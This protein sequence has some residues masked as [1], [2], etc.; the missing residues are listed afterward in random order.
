MTDAALSEGQLT[1]V[2]R[3]A[4]GHTVID[5]ARDLSISEDA[6]TMRLHRA[7]AVFGVQTTVQLALACQRAG[8]L[9]RHAQAARKVRREVA[10]RHSSTCALLQTPVCDC[11]GVDHG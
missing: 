5:I 7:R 11:A 2:R 1:V 9:E 4:A 8:L 6:V 3:V 10:D